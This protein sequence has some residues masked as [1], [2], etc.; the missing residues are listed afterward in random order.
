[1]AT[2]ELAAAFYRDLARLSRAD[3]ARFRRAVAQLVAAL[4]SS[5]PEFPPGLRVKRVQGHREVWELTFAP[6]GRATFAYGEEVVAGE[7]HVVWRRVGDHS[8]LARP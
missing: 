3:R 4:R 5:P 1:M 2:Y 7:A 6:D 8:V